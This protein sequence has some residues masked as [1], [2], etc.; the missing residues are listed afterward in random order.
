M[1]PNIDILEQILKCG[2]AMIAGQCFVEL[3]PDAFD[4]IGFGGVFGQEMQADALA[5][6]S[7]IVL[8][9]ATAMKRG[10]ITNYMDSPGLADSTAK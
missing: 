8:N 3:P 2:A 4:R 10:V 5:P 7:K 6:S 9:Q 1:D